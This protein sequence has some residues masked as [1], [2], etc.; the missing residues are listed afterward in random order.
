MRQPATGAVGWVISRYLQCS[1]GNFTPG[2]ARQEEDLDR[3][4]AK[5]QAGS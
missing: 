4:S 2:S 3:L 1:P 5:V